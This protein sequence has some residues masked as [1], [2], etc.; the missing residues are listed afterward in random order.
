MLE[1]YFFMWGVFYALIHLTD[2]QQINRLTRDTQL[3]DLFEICSYTSFTSKQKSINF[4]SFVVPLKRLYRF[5]SACINIEIRICQTDTTYD[6]KLKVSSLSETALHWRVIWS[7]LYRRVE[8]KDNA[9]KQ[10]NRSISQR[11][12]NAHPGRISFF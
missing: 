9:F 4:V 12:A 2:L 5:A 7:N 3:N 10:I 11:A 1:K 8:L 6:R